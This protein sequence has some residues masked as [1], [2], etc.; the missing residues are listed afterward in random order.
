MIPA[1]EPKVRIYWKNMMGVTRKSKKQYRAA[2]EE[3]M[4]SHKAFMLKMH[5]IDVYYWIGNVK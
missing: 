4:N 5:G 1:P 3:A 2:A